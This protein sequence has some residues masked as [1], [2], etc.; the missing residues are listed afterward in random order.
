MVIVCGRYAEGGEHPVTGE[1]DHHALL[2]EDRLGELIHVA[3]H[4]LV[5]RR[6]LVVGDV[7]QGTEALHV[8]EEARGLVPLG[9]LFQR[10]GALTGEECGDA[11]RHVA[12]EA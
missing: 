2:I 3:A 10:V 12:A 6:E 4:A 7:H 5:H 9:N 11:G 1:L 8:E